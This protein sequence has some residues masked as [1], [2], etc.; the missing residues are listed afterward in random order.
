MSTQQ[1]QQEALRACFLAVAGVELRGDRENYGKIELTPEQRAGI[2]KAMMVLYVPG[3]FVRGRSWYS[4]K[5][6]PQ[7][8]AAVEGYVLKDLVDR[9][10]PNRT[11]KGG[12]TNGLR[13]QLETMVASGIITQERM[14]QLLAA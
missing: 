13:T 6:D 10:S 3:V 1:G 12:S 7:G 5:Y 9:W 11:V 14:D 4:A 8:I 2:V